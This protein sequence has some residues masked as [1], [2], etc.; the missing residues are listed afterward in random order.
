MKILVTGA[1]GFIGEALVNELA[2][3]NI[4]VIAAVRSEINN[5]PDGI[6]KVKIKD[7][8]DIGFSVLLSDV[9]VVVHCAA[10]THISQ[11]SVSNPLI[12]F[13]KTN[14]LGT[15][16]LAQ[17]AAAAGVKRFIFL[18]SIGV[19]GNSTIKPFLE[20]DTPHPK[21]AYAIS[22]YE[23][24]LSLLELAK[25]SNMEITII[26]PPLAY[27]PNVSGNFKLLLN[28]M[29]KNIPLPFN[30]IKNKRSFIALDN[31]V[32]F[33]I[34]CIKHPSAGNE[35]F[36][37]ADDESLSTTELLRRTSL[38]LGKNPILVSINSKLLEF[39]LNL[40]GKKDLARRLL[41]SLEVDIGKA[42]RLLNWS[43]IINV[44]EGLRKMTEDF[45][46]KKN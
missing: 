42:K 2:R 18:S 12:E 14:T 28:W 34:L 30:S 39:F 26:R 43:P 19:S 46:R 1:T 15:L 41:G 37:I 11:E 45:L 38:L 29:N 24:E 6:T 21:G 3:C 13:R 9:D 5:I 33:I 23:A 35:T 20:T 4:N 17:H 8:C 40:L 25:T 27:G 32:D 31:L 36:L 22:K 16:N 7:I 10:K 44:N